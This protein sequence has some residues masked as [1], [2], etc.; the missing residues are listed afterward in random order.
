MSKKRNLSNVI[1]YAS[2]NLSTIFFGLVSVFF[3]ARFFGPE[4]LGQLSLVQST[5]ALFMFLATLGLDHFI[6]RDLAKDRDNGRYIGS[7]MM[8]QF[9]GWLVYSACLILCLY[10]MGKLESMQM[11]IIVLFVLLTTLFTRATLGKLYFQATNQPRAI[12]AS[13]MVS[14]IGALIYLGLAIYLGWSYE[15]VIAYLPLQALIQCAMLFWQYQKLSLISWRDWQVDTHQMLRTVKEAT[16]A[17]LSAAIFPIFMQSDVLIIAHLISNH[18]AGVYSAASKLIIQFNFVGPIITMTFYAALAQRLENHVEFAQ[19]VG[20]MI[21]IFFLLAF[22]VALITAIFSEQIIA[23]LYGAKFTESAE[24]LRVLAWVW[25]FVIPASLYSRLLIMRGQ[26]KYELFKS[27]VVAVTSVSLN[28]ALIPRFGI[29]AAAMSS[30]ISY[31]IADFFIYGI[32]PATRDV[33][34]IAVKSILNIFIMPQKAWQSVIY[35]VSTK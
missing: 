34:F 32:F 21:T 9:L 17:L 23:L 30:V 18:A 26:A 16:P 31:A 35:V 10:W 11:V 2:E 15:W 13:A 20:G 12:A 3:V 4:N 8:A 27:V 7:V 29:V 28:F 14:R 6:V 1:W 22:P 33:F 24:A 25:L 19:M 5:S